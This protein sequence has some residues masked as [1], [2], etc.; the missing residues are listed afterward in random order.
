M[1]DQPSDPIA[2]DLIAG[3]T[4]MVTG[5][6]GFIGSHLV[7]HLVARGAARVVVI[8]S[9]RYGQRSNLGPPAPAVEIVPFTLG[10]DAPALLEEKMAG[11][12]YLFHLAAEKHNQS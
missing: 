10:T 5:G 3:G 1:I 12:R 2:P 8:D 4:V 11:V 6:C 7:R 9:L